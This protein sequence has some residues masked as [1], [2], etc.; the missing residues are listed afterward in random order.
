MKPPWISPAMTR[1]TL[2]N[3]VNLNIE[4]TRLLTVDPTALNFGEVEVGVSKTME[5]N[6]SNNGT[7]LWNFHPGQTM[8]SF[9]PIFPM[10]P[11]VRIHPGLST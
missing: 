10:S 3:T 1:K 4:A 5:I 8:M 9:H 7:H 6:V 11:L 2:P